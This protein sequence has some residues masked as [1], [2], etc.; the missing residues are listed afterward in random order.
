GAG[1]LGATETR[2]GM[3]RQVRSEMLAH[4]DWSHAWSTTAMGDAEGLV[5]VQVAYVRTELPWAG[6]TDLSV[7]V[8]AIHVHLAA[9]LVHDIA[10]RHDR[11]LEHAM[12]RWIGHHEA[13]Q[14]L[15]VLFGLLLQVF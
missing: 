14:V 3:A 8:G 1:G 12:R 7:H 11:L 15:G 13:R 2:H 10:D 4:G 6:Q 5:Q 9:V